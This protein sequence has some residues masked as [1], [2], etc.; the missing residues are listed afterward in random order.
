MIEA[1][2]RHLTPEM[3]VLLGQGFSSY[4]LWRKLTATG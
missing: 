2:L 4:E 1:L 3:F